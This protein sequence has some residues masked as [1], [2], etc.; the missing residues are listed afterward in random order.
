M[1]ELQVRVSYAAWGLGDD[2]HE[3]YDRVLEDLFEA[4]EDADDMNV[5]TQVTL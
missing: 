3:A 5:G 2:W 1:D 4:V